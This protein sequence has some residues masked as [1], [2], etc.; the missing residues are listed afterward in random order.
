L[1]II[2]GA[3]VR[4]RDL[5]FGARLHLL[6]SFG[7]VAAVVVLVKLVRESQPRRRQLMVPAIALA[8]LVACQIVIGVEAW[9][10]RFPSPLW[11]QAQPLPVHP[12]LFRSL[13]YFVGALLFATTLVVTLHAHRRTLPAIEAHAASVVHLEGAL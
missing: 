9:M 7:V 11:N 8:C 13:H 6:L 10:A 12:D 4:H 5:P 3:V 1:Q 2:L